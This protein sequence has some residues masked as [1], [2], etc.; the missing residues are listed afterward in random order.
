VTASFARFRAKRLGLALDVTESI[1]FG[2]H[3]EGIYCTE[4]LEHVPEPFQEIELTEEYPSHLE[5]HRGLSKV[6][7][8]EVEARGLE[9]LELV[10]V[11]ANRFYV[12]QK[13]PA[14][15]G[16]ATCGVGEQQARQDENGLRVIDLAH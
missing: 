10:R 12:F 16:F 5:R 9:F 2:R 1:P 3:Y 4:V 6:F 8:R 7:V 14:R 13:Q 11:P 15:E